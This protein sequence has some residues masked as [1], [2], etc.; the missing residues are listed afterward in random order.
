MRV[1]VKICGL[2]S[3]E[4]IEAAVSAGADAVGL[5]FAASPRQVSAEAA[6]ALGAAVPPFV[7]RVAVCRHPRPEEIAAILECFAPD[8]IQSDLEDEGLVI[9]HP[10]ARFLPV[11]RDPADVA[12]LEPGVPI[13]FEGG[14]SGV[15][16]QADWDQARRLARRHRLILAG[17]LDPANVGEAIR[18][19]R[20]YGVDVS[21]GVEESP[22]RKSRELIEAFMEAVWHASRSI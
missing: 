8:W 5:V 20:P 10:R 3:R 16:E 1:R 18:H 17:G 22:A 13:L 6:C 15:G 11:V 7:T 19:V 2:S 12:R 4:T 14:R 21:S 9:G